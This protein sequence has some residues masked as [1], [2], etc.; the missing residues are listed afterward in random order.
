MTSVLVV[1]SVALDT[2]ETP[3]GKH[4]DI[5]GGS[6]T[7]FSLAASR[8]APT[9]M[10][11][12]VGTDFPAE[13]VEMLRSRE[14]DTAGLEFAEGETFRWHGR[15]VGDM[16]RAE[17]ISVHLNVF[18]KFEPKIP[19]AFSSTPY[20]LLGNSSPQTQRSVLGQLKD[21]K[22]V[23]LD[24]MNFWIDSQR[25]PLE[26]LLPR[27]N[28]LCVNHEEAQQLAGSANCASAIRKLLGMGVPTV[29]IKRGEHGATLATKDFQFS[30]PA[31]PTEKVVDPTGAG[32]SFAGGIVGYLA[33]SG[34][35]A[36]SL[37]KALVYG[38]VMGSLAV[39]EFGTRRLQK[40]TKDEIETRAKILLDMIRV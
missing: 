11:G 27:V 31:Y 30:I 5:L 34:G 2:I 24:T 15:F 32:D 16:S 39:E 38:T 23:M 17:T 14:I 3:H 35:D 40:V 26:E 6:A 37:R 33:R 20:V 19:A 28:A 29:I 21:S 12:V 22:F 4:A 25:K 36:T 18:A 13:H 8:F 7:H 1:G 9:R 10:V